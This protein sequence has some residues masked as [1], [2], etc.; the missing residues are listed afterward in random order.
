MALIHIKAFEDSE[1]QAFIEEVSKILENHGGGEIWFE[2][3]VVVGT[4][5]A[6]RD[7]G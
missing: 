4:D 2:N 7:A 1:T 5:P 3:R 6:D